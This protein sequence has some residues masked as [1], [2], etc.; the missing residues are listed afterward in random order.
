MISFTLISEINKIK[1]N[2]LTTVYNQK[3]LLKHLSNKAAF[4]HFL[5]VKEP[6]EEHDFFFPTR[7]TTA[8]PPSFDLIHIGQTVGRAPASG[9]ALSLHHIELDPSA[10]YVVVTQLR[11]FNSLLRRGIPI[12]KTFNQGMSCYCEQSS[13]LIL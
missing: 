13:T 4:I 6:E 5:H 10:V 2:L 1:I 11:S 3:G 7:L 9:A 8:F 12:L